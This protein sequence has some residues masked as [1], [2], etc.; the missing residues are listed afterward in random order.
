MKLKSLEELLYIGFDGHE[1]YFN[2]NSTNDGWSFMGLRLA[3][4][5]E[6]R[7]S[8]RDIEL[9]DFGYVMPSYLAHYFDYETWRNDMEEN[10]YDSFDV[11]AEFNE[12]G[13]DYYLGLGSGTSI[14]RY[15]NE[16]GIST[17]FD[18][19][20]HFEEVGLSEEEFNYLIFD[21]FSIES[22]NLIHRY[23]LGLEDIDFNILIESKRLGLF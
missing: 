2:E 19:V 18:Y 16:H 23:H 14:F 7:L 3:T 6:L 1:Y 9:E 11:Q 8:Q 10:W 21:H 17:Y 15:F 13:E 22:I 12:D 5:K 4:E 20:E